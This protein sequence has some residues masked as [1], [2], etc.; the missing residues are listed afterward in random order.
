M[1]TE[2]NTTAKISY[3]QQDGFIVEMDYRVEYDINGDVI[4]LDNPATDVVLEFGDIV[5]I[6]IIDQKVSFKTKRT[7]PAADMRKAFVNWVQ[8]TDA[9]L[10][11]YITRNMAKLKSEAIVGVHDCFRGSINDVI[12]G[13]LQKAIKMSYT[14]MF[15]TTGEADVLHNFTKAVAAVSATPMATLSQNDANGYRRVK[16]LGGHSVTAL[17]NDCGFGEVEDTPYYFAK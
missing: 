9:Q 3:A 2:L 15:A 5:P 12:E 13:R 8:G 6:T 10:A 11:R 1:T 4:N 14:K 7:D 17:I 16:K